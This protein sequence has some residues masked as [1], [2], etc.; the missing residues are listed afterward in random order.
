MLPS[1]HLVSYTPLGGVYDSGTPS[2]LTCCHG[3]PPSP[4]WYHH[5][6]H[7][8]CSA[9]PLTQQRTTRVHAAPHWL[10]CWSWICCNCYFIVNGFYSQRCPV[11][12]IHVPSHPPDLLIHP[13]PQSF[14]TH[15]EPKPVNALAYPPRSIGL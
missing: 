6:H 12:H 5:H 10:E 15:H 8:W 4:S 11:H 1:P 7:Q 14:T 9:T 2:C 13:L 3:M